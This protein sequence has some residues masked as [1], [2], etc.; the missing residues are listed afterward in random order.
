M[1]IHIARLQ[2]FSDA[3]T[4]ENKNVFRFA[5]KVQTVQFNIRSSGGRLFH[6]RGPVTAKFLAPMA[7]MPGA[8][9]R[10]RP[11]TAWMDNSKTW[12]GLLVEELVRMTEDR[13]KW[14]KCV[15]AVANRRI[16]DGRLKNR[17]DVHESVAQLFRRTLYTATGRS[18][19]LQ[20]DG[21]D[22]LACAAAAA[23]RSPS[24]Q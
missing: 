18:L 2:K 8:R 17:T 10:G 21:G 23:G 14:R 4:A 9:R 22:G 24:N 6:T 15:H 1:Q 20:S 3:L 7:P 13:D 5:A 19:S 16:E 12:T 11:R